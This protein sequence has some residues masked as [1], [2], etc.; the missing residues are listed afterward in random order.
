MTIRNKYF[1]VLLLAIITCLA[2]KGQYTKPSADSPGSFKN[3]LA[4]YHAATAAPAIKPARQYLHLNY[5]R[6]NNQ[7]MSWPDYPLT[8]EEIKRRDE[9]DKQNKKLG[10]AIA[11]DIITS[12]LSKKKKIAAIPKF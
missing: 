7:L 11:K 6:P 3:N 9:E 12:L 10:N 5:T 8:P 4:F 1:N 2:A